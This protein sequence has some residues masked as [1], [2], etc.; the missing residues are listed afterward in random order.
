MPVVVVSVGA[1][2]PQDAST[3]RFNQPAEADGMTTNLQ[4]RPE[5][6]W[7]IV[8]VMPYYFEQQNKQHDRFAR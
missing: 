7:A 5:L 6:S 2:A 3:A 4:L 1:A 8:V